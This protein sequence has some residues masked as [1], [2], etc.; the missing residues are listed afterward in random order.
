M[1]NIAINIINKTETYLMETALEFKNLV[2]KIG[3]DDR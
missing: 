1:S 3:Y 2:E